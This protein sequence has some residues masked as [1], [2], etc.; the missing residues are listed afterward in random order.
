MTSLSE[1]NLSEALHDLVDVPGPANLAD[2]ALVGA[3]R[4]RRRRMALSGAAALAVVGLVAVPFAIRPGSQPAPGQS[5]A[6]AAAMA[7]SS[8]SNSASPFVAT[9]RCVAAP[10]VSPTVKTVAEADWPQFVRIAI[11][12]LPPRTDYTMQSGYGVCT[13]ED[14]TAANAYAVINLGGPM[15][16]HGHLTLNLVARAD[17]D[18]PLTCDAL[19]K[20]VDTKLPRTPDTPKADV[21]FCEEGTAST[22]FVFGIRYYNTLTVTAVYADHRSVWME[23]HPAYPGRSFEIDADALRAVVTDRALVDLLPAA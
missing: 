23:S 19:R 18:A 8:S 11:K 9:Q 13:P 1:P 4:V 5:A 7:G 2:Q 21:L 14:T 20:H 3:R 6:G 17:R 10:Q 16:E 12:K 15:R 22:P